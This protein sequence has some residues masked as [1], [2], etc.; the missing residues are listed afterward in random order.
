MRLIIFF[1]SL[2]SL[3]ASW[4]QTETDIQLAQY[5]YASGELDKALPYY[6]KIYNSSPTKVYFNRYFECLVATKDYKSA[7]KLV[8]KQ[9]NQNRSDYD[10]KVMLA[11][12]YEDIGE[13]EKAEKSYKE[14]IENLPDNP[15]QI[16]SI[17]QTLALKQKFDMAKTVLDKG[18]KLASYY[19]FNFQYADLY[20]QTGKKKEMIAEYLDYLDLQPTTIESI[21]ASLAARLDLSANENADYSLLKEQLLMRSQKI[22]A[23]VVFSELLIWMYTQ[24]KNFDGAFTQ[25]VA[26]DKRFKGDGYRVFELGEICVENKNYSV[27]RKCFNYI[28]NLGENNEN[29]IPAFKALLNTHFLQITTNRNFSMSEIDSTIMTYEQA[30]NKLGKSSSTLPVVLEHTMILAF[31]ANQSDKAQEE[32]KAAMNFGGLTD[33]QKAQIKMQ[34]A[35]I[36]V[37]SGD[38]WEAS[39][40]YMQVDNDFKFESIGQEA[41]FKNAKVF[42]YDGEFDYA[43]AQ[44]NVLK[45]STSKL[46]A[47]D[48]MQLSVMITDNYGLDSNFQVM[49]WFANADLLIEQHKYDEAFKLYDSIQINFPYHSLADEILFKKGKA[50]EMRG[51]WQKALDYY[52]DLLKFHGQDILADDALFRSGDINENIL[53]NKEKA[54]EFYRRLAIE[55]KGS[56]YSAEARK[57]IRVLRGDKN[58]SDDEL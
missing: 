6:E 47:N 14:I 5:Y 25:V 30:L 28:I 22:N 49:S 51:E 12:F 4:A 29:Y 9:I 2:F 23:S 53:S 39:I 20:A 31:Y 1:I 27:A 38:I 56:L 55:Y 40:L 13:T 34:L 7:E 44:L 11:Q 35:D 33:V 16:I 21:E 36:N 37:L 17:Y 58:V 32:L 43:Q 3:T 24:S 57:R 8:K 46:I 45:E 26:I 10:M 15:S 48:A 18:K 19:P 54:L 50:M 41:K 42:Y 52:D